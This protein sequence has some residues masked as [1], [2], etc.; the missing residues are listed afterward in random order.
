MTDPSSLT[1]WKGASQEMITT[2]SCCACVAD[3]DTVWFPLSRRDGVTS[4][5]TEPHMLDANA[6]TFLSTWI[7]SFAA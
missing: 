6:C 5:V 4:S 3:A 2:P 1:R 7:F